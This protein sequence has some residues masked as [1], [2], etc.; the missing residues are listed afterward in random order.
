MKIDSSAVAMAS[1][2]K[3]QAAQ[4]ATTA[5]TTNYYGN[6]GVHNKST[7][8]DTV[9]ISQYQLE[10]S[11]TAFASGKHQLD[12]QQKEV[13][14]LND[15]EQQ[16]ENKNQPQSLVQHLG[17]LVG[18]SN[19]FTLP[20][21]ED[22]PQIVM[23]KRMLE[24]LNNVT[25][26]KSGGINLFGSADRG[27]GTVTSFDALSG[28][29]ASASSVSITAGRL[30]VTNLNNSG[31][32]GAANGRWTRQ[33]VTS[34]FEQGAENTAFVSKG[35]AVTSDGRTIDFNITMEM[36]RSFE[37]AYTE[38][39]AE[40]EFVFT[41]PLVINLENDNAEVSDVSFYFDL[42]ADGTKENIS[43][44]KDGSGFLALDKNGDGK[45]NDGSEL[46]GAKTGDGFSELAAYDE[47]GNGWIDESDSVFDR[48]TVW[49]KAADG[50]DKMIALSEAGVGA[51]FLGSQKTQFSLTNSSGE[52]Q[53]IIRSSGVF[54]HE[55]GEVGTIQHVDFKA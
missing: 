25:G 9:T 29:Y 33:T 10:G 5:T 20:T 19:N 42:D 6:G 54:L 28:I 30:T 52:E 36:S 24:V 49:T 17:N 14:N 39:S 12:S 15:T 2:R 37:R 40:E 31:E 7:S 38:V 23:L 43:T 22:D 11:S 47:D 3:Y 34:V 46:F 41:D 35:T 51:I 18:A 21:V 13:V 48:L 16:K 8:I 44:L 50:S 55:N 27:I 53:A 26:K 45:I 4:T 1:T 32:S